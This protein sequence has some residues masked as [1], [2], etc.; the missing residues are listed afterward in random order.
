LRKLRLVNYETEWNGTISELIEVSEAVLPQPNKV[1]S[2]NTRVK[3]LTEKY[4]TT[5]IFGNPD[6]TRRAG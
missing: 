4:T 6:K 5:P 3:A 2:S 1:I